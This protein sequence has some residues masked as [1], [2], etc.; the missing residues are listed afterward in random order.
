MTLAVLIA[1]TPQ[2]DDTSASTGTASSSDSMSSTSLPTATATN[3]ATSTASTTEAG[4]TESTETAPTGT[5]DT[6]TTT[7][8][9]T[10]DTNST[11]TDSTDT[12]GGPPPTCE[13]NR[14]DMEFSF[15]L[16]PIGDDEYQYPG[17]LKT[18]ECVVVGVSPPVPGSAT[19]DFSCPDDGRGVPLLTLEVSV[20]PLVD[21]PVLLVGDSVILQLWL[22]DPW[23][24]DYSVTLRDEFGTLLLARNS[25]E[26]FPGSP[27]NTGVEPPPTQ[28]L[29][30]LTA[31]HPG[32]VCEPECFDQDSEFCHCS[33]RLALDF[34]FEGVT[35]RVYDETVRELGDTYMIYMASADTPSWPY[36]CIMP[37]DIPVYWYSY[38]VVAT[39]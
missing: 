26:G 13:P 15:S 33:E 29:A 8:T 24:M 5:S 31:V 17:E 20:T 30:P 12:S 37:Y 34:S 27:H 16:S 18:R 32:S 39:S 28:L 21:L 7:G 4:G 23:W 36:P 22:S 3:S 38:V 6:D 14:E 35:A 1:C 10:T 25:A 11:G 9:D 19:Y 2:Q